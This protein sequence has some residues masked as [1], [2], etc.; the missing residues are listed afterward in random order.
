MNQSLSINALYSLRQANICTGQIRI[1]ITSRWMLRAIKEIYTSLKS[2]C[3]ETN[4]K[5]F[6]FKLIHRIVVT[7]K[8]LYRYGIKADDECL[9]CGEKGIYL[10]IFVNKG[11]RNLYSL[12]T[13]KCPSQK[14]KTLQVSC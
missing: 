9:Y 8:E 13:K 14:C 3:K 4:L 10:S 11:K 1:T 12:A 7:K 2:I 6:Q 5:Q